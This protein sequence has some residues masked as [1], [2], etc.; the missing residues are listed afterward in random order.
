MRHKR[1]CYQKVGNT[2]AKK[3]GKHWF[4]SILPSFDLSSIYTQSTLMCVQC[5]IV[6]VFTLRA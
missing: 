3:V 4:R 1:F 6:H 2:L 5:T